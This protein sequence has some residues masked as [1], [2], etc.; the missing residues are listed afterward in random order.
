[1][2]DSQLDEEIVNDE[3]VQGASKEGMGGT[4][5]S[6]G[7]RHDE[8]SLVEQNAEYLAGWKRA[9]ADYENLQKRNSEARDDDRRR[10]RINMA[11]ELLPVVDNFDQAIKFAP[12]E[13]PDNLKSWFAGIQHIARQF[14]EVLKSLG[15]EPIKAVGEQFNPNVHESGGSK[16]DEAR[17]EHEVVEELIKGWKLGEIVLRPSKVIVNEKPTS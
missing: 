10:V 13:V 12:T 4:D 11:Q 6:I 2:T 5:A 14:E 15:V 16:F 9:L 1:M 8:P 3:G 17:P 7:A